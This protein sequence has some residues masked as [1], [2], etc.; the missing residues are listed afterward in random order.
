MEEITLSEARPGTRYV[1]RKIKDESRLVNRL[2][3]MGLMTGNTLEICQN[4]KKQPV[5]VFARDTLIAVGR[6]ESKKITLGGLEHE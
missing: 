4:Y 6:E 3:S 1:I 5:L 2:S